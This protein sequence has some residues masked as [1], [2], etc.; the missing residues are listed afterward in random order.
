[1]KR[2]TKLLLICLMLLSLLCGCGASSDKAANSAAMSLPETPMEAPGYEE[3]AAFGY[4]VAE[5]ESAVDSAGTRQNSAL[6]NAKLIYTADISLQT[7]AFDDSAAKL[8]ALVEELGGYFESSSVNN[9]SSYRRGSYTV[10]VP[11]ESFDGFCTAV[12]SI[13]QLTYISRSAEDISENYYDTESRLLTQQTKLERLQELLSR[14][15]SMEDIITIE[16]AISE[17]ELQIESL[18]GTLRRYDSLVGF[19][20]VCI[21]LEEVYRLD[22]VE[23]APIGFGAKFLSALKSGC[24]SFVRSLQALA[25]TI[26]YNWAGILLFAAAAAV[27]VCLVVRRVKKRRAPAEKKPAENKEKDGQNS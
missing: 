25:L 20:T 15:E 26:A 19:S 8:G 11:A 6:A 18:T 7:T 5:T 10:R 14:A 2:N 27:V 12:G 3:D 4:E 21:S 22:E 9:Y 23:E 16:S 1:M 17:T 13:C 24:S